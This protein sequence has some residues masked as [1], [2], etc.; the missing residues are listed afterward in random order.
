MC[1]V[2]AGIRSFAAW[3][4]LL[5]L[6]AVLGAHGSVALG[7]SVSATARALAASASPT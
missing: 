6:A 2:R 5:T 1:A 7:G 4:R 3:M